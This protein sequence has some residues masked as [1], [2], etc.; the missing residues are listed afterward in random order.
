MPQLTLAELDCLDPALDL[1]PAAPPARAELLAAGLHPPLP[2]CGRSLVWGFGLLAAARSAGL[3]GLE[4]R[5]IAERSPEEMLALALRLEGRAGAYRWGEKLGLLG[6]ARSRGFSLG[7]LD[8]LIEGRVDPRL[9]RRVQEYSG[10]PGSLRGLVD[11]SALDL[12][13]ALA[14]RGLPEP[15]FEL[16]GSAGLSFSERRAFLGLLHEAVARLRLSPEET[17]AAARRALE[18]ARPLE[19]LRERVFPT[20]AA[21]RRRWEELAEELVGGSGVRLLPPED[22]EGDLFEVS[23]RFRTRQALA[24]RLGALA[25]VRGRFDELSEFLR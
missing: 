15:A 13:T 4:C 25:R 3:P 24:R 19:A 14:V 8:L 12:R 7:K 20:L 16:A 1:F 11:R 21:M 6:F 23:F 5:R 9:E 2:V 22:F 17:L 18:D 10:L